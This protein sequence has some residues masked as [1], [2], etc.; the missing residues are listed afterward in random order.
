MTRAPGLF[1]RLARLE[2]AA[3][4][5]RPKI[6]VVISQRGEDPAA[7]ERRVA[8]IEG[9]ATIVV[10]INKLY[11]GKCYFDGSLAPTTVSLEPPRS[12]ATNSRPSNP[13]DPW[14]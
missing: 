6:A 7:L 5:S 2:A 1:G 8:E 12:T 10:V 11:R 3:A 13:G 4:A 9:T 14:T